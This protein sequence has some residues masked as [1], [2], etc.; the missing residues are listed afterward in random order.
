MKITKGYF[1]NMHS[2]DL[3]EES[4]ETFN[5]IFPDGCSI[6]EFLD[7]KPHI[8]PPKKMGGDSCE[9]ELPLGPHS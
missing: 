2:V 4:T 8:S 1:K 3:S 9:R 6:R 5:D 7:V